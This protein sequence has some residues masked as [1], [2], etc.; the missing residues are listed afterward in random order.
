MKFDELHTPLWV[1][2]TSE[3]VGEEFSLGNT[4]LGELAKASY[5]GNI[6]ELVFQMRNN[7]GRYVYLYTVQK[8]ADETLTI[9]DMR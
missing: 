1:N 8:N 7:H 2:D 4:K 9:K 3:Y 6:P 5:V